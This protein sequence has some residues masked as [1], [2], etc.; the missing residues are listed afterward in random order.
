MAGK[1][2]INIAVDPSGTK[3]RVSKGLPCKKH[4]LDFSLSLQQG[5][6]LFMWVSKGMTKVQEGIG[7]SP[8]G[9][10]MNMVL[11]DVTRQFYLWVPKLEVGTSYRTPFE[12][13]ARNVASAAVGPG[14]SFR[15]NQANAKLIR[16][17]LEKGKLGIVFFWNRC[18]LDDQKQSR[19][20]T[21]TAL[22]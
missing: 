8:H 19:S 9:K 4:L 21:L 14:A 10:I 15:C 3:A 18:L 12:S 1:R 17:L 13:S 16:V 22:P 20:Q 7:S 5:I 2:I 11:S 6:S